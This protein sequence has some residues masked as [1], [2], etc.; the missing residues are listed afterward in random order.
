M[1]STRPL[2]LTTKWI[3]GIHP[4]ARSRPTA[5]GVTTI[6]RLVIISRKMGLNLLDTCIRMITCWHPRTWRCFQPVDSTSPPTIYTKRAKATTNNANRAIRALKL[7]A[8]VAWTLTAMTTL[9]WN[10]LERYT[11]KISINSRSNRRHLVSLTI[12]LTWAAT[13]KCRCRIWSPKV[14]TSNH[15]ARVVSIRQT[16]RRM[17]RACH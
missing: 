15:V 2:F 11:S 14:K 17:I 13:V 16:C 12:S 5:A 7:K 4:L 3:V 10:W 8:R 6:C 9:T 1:R